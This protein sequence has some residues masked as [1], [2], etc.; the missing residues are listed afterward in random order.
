MI[1]GNPKLK[2]TRTDISRYLN[3]KSGEHPELARYVER[4]MASCG[5]A[6]RDAVSQFGFWLRSKYPK[7][8]NRVFKWAQKQPEILAEIY[9][10]SDSTA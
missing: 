10:E 4:Y 5:R 1:R 7:E 3:D 9:A 6:R 2:V 8:F